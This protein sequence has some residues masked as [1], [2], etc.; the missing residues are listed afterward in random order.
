M[1]TIWIIVLIAVA[2]IVVGGIAWALRQRQ[3]HQ[4][5][6]RREAARGTREEAAA[7]ERRAERARLEAEDQAA[8]ARREDAEARDLTERADEVDPDVPDADRS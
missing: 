7:K 4:L 8:R 3:V 6:E 1:D 5:Q 2:I